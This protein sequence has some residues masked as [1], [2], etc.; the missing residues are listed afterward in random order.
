L[1]SPADRSHLHLGSFFTVNTA[2]GSRPVTRFGKFLRTAEPGLKL[3][4]PT[5]NTV[6]G[7]SACAL[8]RSRLTGDQDP[9]QRV[10]HI[11]IS[12]ANSR[13]PREVLRNAI[14]SLD[15]VGRSSPMSNRSS[16]ATSPVDA[17]MRSFARRRPSHAAVKQGTR[18]GHGWLR[19][20]DRQ[21]LVTTSFPTKRSVRHETTSR[22]TS[23]SR[24]R[25]NARG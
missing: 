5:L 9:R 2:A 13:P 23:G 15:A 17:P 16:A 18:C 4:M 3:K 24:L 7:L 1:P 6:A 14:T 25:A 12:V 20:R 21:R 10:R 8:T 19:L 11:P 22:R